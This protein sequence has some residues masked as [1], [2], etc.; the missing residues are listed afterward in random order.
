MVSEED[1]PFDFIRGMSTRQ[2]EQAADT[3]NSRGLYSMCSSGFLTIH[4]VY[5]DERRVW[6]FSRGGLALT[7]AFLFGSA[8]K[9][10]EI[11]HRSI[12]LDH[13]QNQGFQ[14]FRSLEWPKSGVV[15]A[16]PTTRPEPQERELFLRDDVV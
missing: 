11:H 5:A 6:Q 3:G 1:A 15:S 9:A 13:R 8:W 10:N 14:R 2:A 16:M 12:N 7:D 4:E